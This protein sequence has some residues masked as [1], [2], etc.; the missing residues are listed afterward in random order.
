MKPLSITY[1]I[2]PL[3]ELVDKYTEE[4]SKY[5]RLSP[6]EE[7]QLAIKIRNDDNDDALETLVNANLRFVVAIA[8]QYQNK[9]LSLN[10]LINEG[11]LGLIRAARKFDETRGFKFTSYAVWWIRQAILQALTEQSRLIKMPSHRIHAHSKIRKIWHRFEQEFHREPTAEELMKLSAQKEE[12]VHCFLRLNTHSVN[13]EFKITS[14]HNPVL[15]DTLPDVREANLSDC[16]DHQAVQHR[17]TRVLKTLPE[18]DR[19][20]VIS[21]F[22]FNGTHAMTLEEIGEKHDLSSERVRQIKEKCINRLRRRVN[23]DMLMVYK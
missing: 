10:D 22:G 11:N 19:E 13:A 15:T 18:R 21:Y 8:K 4:I 12:T 17:L 20:I 7:A 2:T 23:P 5:P 3:N 1:N 6:D 16:L 14:T 9:N